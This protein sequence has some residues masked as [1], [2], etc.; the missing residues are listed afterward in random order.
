MAQVSGHGLTS[1]TRHSK[2]RDYAIPALNDLVARN[3][4]STQIPSLNLSGRYQPLIYLLIATLITA[5]Q[6]KAVVVVDADRRFDITRVLH[7]TPYAGSDGSDG[8]IVTVTESDL[9]HIHVYRP[10]HS[11]REDIAKVVAS[12]EKFML[13]GAHGSRAR[14]WWGTVVIGGGGGASGDVAVTAGWRGWLRVDLQD[15]RGFAVG[16][17]AEEALAE[18]DRRQQAVSDSRW[19]ATS[20]WGDFEFSED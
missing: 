14:E 15:V 4:R 5:P 7:C 12:A 3:F 9:A 20:V 13:Y 19:V 8:K 17:S 10:A 11:S 1:L 18:R 16:L 2:L 6:N